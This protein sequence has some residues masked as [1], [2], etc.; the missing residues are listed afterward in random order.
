MSRSRFF[1]LNR[2]ASL[3]RSWKSRC[4]CQWLHRYSEPGLYP[5]TMHQPRNRVSHT[6]R[7]E[8]RKRWGG[9]THGL[10]G[11][12]RECLRSRCRGKRPFFNEY[13]CKAGFYLQSNFVF[14]H[15]L[16]QVN[17]QS[18]ITGKQY[19]QWSFFSGFYSPYA[20]PPYDM[21]MHTIYL[22]F[23]QM[24]SAKLL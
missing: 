6:P 3:L 16:K 22:F 17:K 10:W 12:S 2:S 13:R 21:I 23:M 24:P 15:L 11:I 9:Q 5:Q 19:Q 8:H 20:F 18:I 7:L 1:H 4:A 14:L